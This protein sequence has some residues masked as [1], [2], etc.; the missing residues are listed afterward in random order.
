MTLALL[1]PLA[2]YAQDEDSAQAEEEAPPQS[3]R[4]LF[5]EGQSAYSEGDYDSAVQRWEAAYEMDARPLL[6]YNLAQ[7]YERL[8]RL[9]DA[10]GAYQL[11]IEGTGESDDE[12]LAH[13]RQRSA[14]LR[15]RLE[16]TGIVL[17]GGPPGGNVTVDGEGRGLLPIEGPIQVEAGSH[18]VEVVLDGYQSF[19][20]TVA[21]GEGHRVNVGVVMAQSGGGQAGGMSISPLGLAIAGA[22]A[23]ISIGGVVVGAIALSNGQNAP[24][25]ESPEADDA[26]TLALV[27]DIMI[28]GGLAIA[29][30]GAILTFVLGGDDGESESDVSMVPFVDPQGGGVALSGRF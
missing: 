9:A 2:A 12:R 1:A 14:S 21:V 20:A 24:R 15:G 6:Q 26:R 7:A 8:G 22:G 27:A 4:E 18:R 10:I 23:A 28:F 19:E 11:Y 30:T 29:L 25:R 16:R 3:A 13:A 5:L 17:T